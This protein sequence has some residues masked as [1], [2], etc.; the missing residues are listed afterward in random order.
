MGNFK[1]LIGED[2]DDLARAIKRLLNSRLHI[3][4]PDVLIGK[5]CSQ[6]RHLY[7][8]NP[9]VAVMLLN[10]EL[11]DNNTIELI[12]EL[13]MT[14]KGPIAAF[15]GMPPEY[16]NAM[17]SAGCTEEFVKPI[18]LEMFVAYIDKLRCLTALQDDFIIL[19]EQQHAS[20][21]SARGR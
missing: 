12:R 9:G 21:N 20:K 17:R 5:T 14:F 4:S 7:H 6:V 16:V 15:T 1:I 8:K 11:A 3:L 2:S 10:Y 13:K 19:E 18:N